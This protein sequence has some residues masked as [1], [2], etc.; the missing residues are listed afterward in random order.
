MSVKYL[1]DT[2]IIFWDFDGVIKDS[3]EVKS[4]AFGQLFSSFGRG[5]KKKI[6]NHHKMNGGMSRF[7]KLPIYIKWT[8]QKST[9][10]MV[11]DYSAK[12][13]T[14]VRQKVIDSQ[15]VPGVLNYLS[16]NHNKQ[17]FFLVTATPQLEI[18]EI[19][20]E[21][22]IYDHFEQIIGSPTVKGESIKMLLDKYKVDIKRAVMVGDSK[23]DYEAAIL[24]NIQFVLRKTELN[25]SLQSWLNCQMIDNFL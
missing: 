17:K 8:E 25:K 13:S 15:W 18:E 3:V 7:D 11:D 4:V 23:S 6:I 22:D 21:L 9:Q 20:F 2:Q 10:E 14:L 24:N 1:N 19:L 12:F 5:I 16:S